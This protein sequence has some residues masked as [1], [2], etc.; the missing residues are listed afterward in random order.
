M[1]RRDLVKA[2]GVAAMI[3]LAASESG[4]GGGCGDG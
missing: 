2:M 4:D 1:D 3:P